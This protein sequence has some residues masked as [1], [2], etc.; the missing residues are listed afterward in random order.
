MI[1]RA[2][3]PVLKECLNLISC[4]KMAMFPRLNYGNSVALELFVTYLPCHCN[5]C[6]CNLCQDDDVKIAMIRDDHLVQKAI[7]LIFKEQEKSCEGEKDIRELRGGLHAVNVAALRLMESFARG[8]K[9]VKQ[10]LGGIDSLTQGLLKLQQGKI[11][12]S[13]CITFICLHTSRKY[14]VLRA[15]HLSG[16]THRSV[17][18]KHYRLASN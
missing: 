10:L 14:S 15:S 9:H 2:V 12:L 1:S 11:L 8:N 18:Q 17:H 4:I 3:M 13:V 7:S 16:C 6:H 5:L